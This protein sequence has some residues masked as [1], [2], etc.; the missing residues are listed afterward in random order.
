MGGASGADTIPVTITGIGD[1]FLLWNLDTSTWFD[2]ACQAAGRNLTSE[3]W[4]QF[5]PR[6]EEYRATCPQWPALG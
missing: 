1:S 3:E 4:K 2:I 6:N 5:G